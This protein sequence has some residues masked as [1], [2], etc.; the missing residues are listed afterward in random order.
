MI[1]TA[2]TLCV[3]VSQ[4]SRQ[5]NASKDAAAASARTTLTDMFTA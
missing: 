3:L 2:T 4:A 1:A 5:K